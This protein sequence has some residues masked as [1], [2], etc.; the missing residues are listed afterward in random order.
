MEVVTERLLHEERKLKERLGSERSREGAMPGKQRPKGKG[1][2]GKFGQIRRN[3]NEEARSNKLK[4]NKAEVRRRGSSSS[5]SDCVGLMVNHL[6][7]GNSP[8]PSMNG[9]WIQEQPATCVVTISCLL[10]FKG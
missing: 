6:L 8:A 10:S 5:D 1:P 4:V 2:T 9:S 3:C 7:S